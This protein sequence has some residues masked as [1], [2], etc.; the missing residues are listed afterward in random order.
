LKGAPRFEPSVRREEIVTGPGTGLVE[1]QERNVA[2]C[3][4]LNDVADTLSTVSNQR[5]CV[6]CTLEFSRVSGIVYSR[7]GVT[8]YDYPGASDTDLVDMN[9]AGYAIA[10]ARFGD[11]FL[12]SRPFLFVPTGR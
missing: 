4:F 3:G 10:H 11:N 12:D 6:G 8:V 1:R 7:A 5:Q 9:S 2:G